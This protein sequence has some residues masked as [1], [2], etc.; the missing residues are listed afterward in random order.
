MDTSN[1]ILRILLM[2]MVIIQIIVLI[3]MF[4]TTHKRY[5]E[6][7]KFW[8]DMHKRLTNIVMDHNLKKPKENIENEQNF[9]DKK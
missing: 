5:K 3:Q 4:Y 9:T 6:D 2:C 8:D 7:Q 1:L